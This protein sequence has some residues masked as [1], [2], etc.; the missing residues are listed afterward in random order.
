MRAFYITLFVFLFNFCLGQNNN[1]DIHLFPITEQNKIGFI[2]SSGKVIIKPVFLSA[3]E[4]SEGL[5]PARIAGTYGYIDNTGKF[6]IRPQYDY[7]TEFSEGHAIVYIGGKSFF[8]NKTGQK[9]FENAF[10]KISPF[11]SGRSKVQTSTGKFG[12]IDKT[13]KLVID[14]IFS[15]INRFID[16]LAVVRGY[17]DKGNNIE[18]TLEYGV[19]DTL[20]RFIISYGSVK[21][22]KDLTNRYFRASLPIDS[23]DMHAYYRN[24]AIFDHN[25][26]LVL[27]K[28]SGNHNSIEGV[29]LDGLIKMQLFRDKT[30]EV[31]RPP[32][33]YE[34]IYAGYI[35]L[36]GELIIDNY[37]FKEGT[38]FANNRAFVRDKSGKYSLIDTKGK[39]IKEIQFDKINTT[40]FI[41]G[42]A[43]VGINWNWGLIDT[44]GTFLIKPQYSEINPIDKNYFFFTKQDSSIN[45]G[46]LNGVSSIDGRILIKPIIEDYDRK[47]FQNGLLK[48]TI[49]NK[50][51]YINIQGTIVWQE[52]E[53][54]TKLHNLNIDYMNNHYFRAASR[55]SKYDVGY[56]SSANFPKRITNSQKFPSD[57]LNLI[58]R[59]DMKITFDGQYYGFEAFI[60]NTTPDNYLFVG[61]DEYLDMNIQALD[62]N[63]QWMDIDYPFFSKSLFSV[64]SAFCLAPQEYW[65]FCIPAYEGE[66]KTRLRLKL[67]CN[68]LNENLIEQ[69]NSKAITIYSNEF[70]GSINPGQFWRIPK[71][72]P[73]GLMDL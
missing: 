45:S 65:S 23:C 47:G 59:R 60:A 40:G 34:N 13:G 64:R 10:A 32:S 30:P 63:G 37:N 8:I 46:K 70:K 41:N 2:D 69:T 39:I 57:K 6:V 29:P 61:T 14:T 5:A 21:Y 73:N 68:L 17:A 52:K 66:I 50:T 43:F 67:V 49:E 11:K 44:N 22:I 4:F 16:G 51:S 18:R 20:G 7:A 1:S 9:L 54:R 58:V 62:K 71:Q 42:K 15:Q 35:N 48:C 33:T 56:D 19:I 24:N 31:E 55:K 36:K 72:T 25:G 27:F 53:C 28:N 12:C 38:D 3:G 26:N